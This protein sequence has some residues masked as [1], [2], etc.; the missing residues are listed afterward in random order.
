[1]DT[2]DALAAVAEAIKQQNQLLREIRDLLK[3]LPDRVA[4]QE[5]MRDETRETV[6][7]MQDVLAPVVRQMASSG[8]QQGQPQRR[9]A[10]D[11]FKQSL[12]IR[13]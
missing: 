6:R 7:Q 2:N 5:M 10:L 8:G 13:D 11:G 12:G 1:M 3:A 4:V 9:S